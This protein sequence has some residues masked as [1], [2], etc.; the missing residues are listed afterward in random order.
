MR[1]FIAVAVAVV[2]RGVMGGVE[3]ASIVLMPLPGVLI[4]VLTGY[5]VPA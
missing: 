5:A 3:R 2:R 1:P 4:V